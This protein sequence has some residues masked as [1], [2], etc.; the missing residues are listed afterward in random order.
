MIDHKPSPTPMNYGCKLSNQGTDK[1]DDPALYH[2]IVGALQH[3][4]ITRLELALC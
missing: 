3:V 1:F 2:S 4:T